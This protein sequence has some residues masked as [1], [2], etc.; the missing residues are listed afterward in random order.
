MSRSVLAL[1]DMELQP[2]RARRRLQSLDMVSACGRLAGFTSTAM[3]G[4]RGHQLAQQLQP[5]WPPALR[6]KKLTP[7]RLPP[8]RLRLATRPSWTGSP[9]V[10]KTI[11]IVVV[12]ALAAS[13][14]EGCSRDDHARP[15]GEP[16]RPPA[17][18]ADRIGLRPAVFDRHVLALDIAGFLQALAERART[19]REPVRRC[20]AEK[21]DHRHRRLL[22]ARR[23]RPRRRRAAEQRDELPPPHAGHGGSLP[24]VPPPIIPA[25]DPPG[26]GGLTHQEPAGGRVSRSLGQT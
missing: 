15:G 10:A 4:R 17:P 20:A 9:P 3:R 5:L 13:A 22:R 7:V 24:R 26:A 1:Q 18:A 23:E 8:G 2:E 14:G 21:P 12:A 11:G 6:S 19:V 16:D 25:R